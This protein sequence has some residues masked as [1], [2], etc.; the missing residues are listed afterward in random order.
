MISIQDI[1]GAP[2]T[3][4]TVTIRHQSLEMNHGVSVHTAEADSPGQYLVEDLPMGMGGWWLVEVTIERPGR[5]A[6][7]IDVQLTL[8]GP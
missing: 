7:V 6:V 4:A 3:D 8:E 2:V 5:T 1:T